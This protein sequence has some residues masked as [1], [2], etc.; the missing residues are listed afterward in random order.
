[1][2]HIMS[3]QEAVSQIQDGDCIGINAFLALSNPESLHDAITERFLETGHP[4]RLRLFCS[5]G[6]GCWDKT[7]YADPYIAAG[8]V[9]EI[10]AG[11]FS[12]MPE[13]VRAALDGKIEAYN[14]PLG[15]LSHAVR[16]AA[17]RKDGI[18][19]EVGLNIFVDP[20]VGSYAMNERSKKQLVKLVEVNGKEYLFYETPK[21][22]FAFIKGTTVDPNG[23]ISFENEY[24]TVDALSLA[25]A[26]KANGGKVFVEVENV[27]HNFARPRSVIVPGVLVDAVVVNKNRNDKMD[28]SGALSGDIHVPAS[29]MD[30]FMGNLTRS[31]KAKTDSLDQSEDI[32][33]HRAARELQP[34]HIIN[35]GIGIPETVGKYASK[36]GVL[37]QITATV[38]AGGVGG[39]PAPGVSFGA[40]IGA[41]MISDMAVQF[42][43]YDGGGL[44]ICFMGGF[45]VDR[46]GNVNAHQIE[47]RFAG[48]G[49]FANIT[50]F[51]KT[52]VFCMNFTTKGIDVRE[53]NGKIEIVNEGAVHKFNS[54]IRAISF[55]AKNA[56]AHGQ[57][58]L[59][60]TER[61]VFELTAN[62]LRLAE[63]YPGIDA[64]KDIRDMLDF[65]L[66]D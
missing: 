44:D 26:T 46:F 7:R 24:L 53:T 41:D 30:Y 4:A 8:A 34:E 65:E 25:Q 6:F 22:D 5:A 23:N 36:L 55:S 39:L 40:T 50:F 56:L 9:A 57:R 60:V 28:F 61:C 35:I 47:G 14:L 66:A 42:D 62:G 1:M 15:A 32:I 21:F 52:V 49:G 13:A 48:I 64:Q 17:S 31:K 43:F 59:Y 20:R 10:V 33:G 2:F 63:V 16:A 11:H 38:E 18:L 12:S 45:E 29:H 27:S 3:A 37:R 51:T 58:V 54:K 19:S